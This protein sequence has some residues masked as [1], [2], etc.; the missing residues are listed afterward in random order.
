MPSQDCIVTKNDHHGHALFLVR[1]LDVI[2]T[3]T[4]LSPNSPAFYRYGLTQSPPLVVL[5]SS[6]VVSP[7]L[8]YINL[9]QVQTQIFVC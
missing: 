7:H 9:S 3:R 1:I 4:N 5:S 6:I 2:E 8:R